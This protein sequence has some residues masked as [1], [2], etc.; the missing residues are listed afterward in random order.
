VQVERAACWRFVGV[1]P[2]GKARVRKA[3]LSGLL[4]STPPGYFLSPL[5]ARTR[6]LK[7][8]RRGYKIYFLYLG[9]SGSLLNTSEHHF[10][11]G[12]VCAHD[13]KIY[14]LRR[15][16]DEL[17]QEILPESPDTLQISSYH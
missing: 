3:A 13:S 14:Y 9:D 8:F 15:Y 7:L 16:L 12:G 10:V 2:H 5:L 17:A 4:E 11:L 1:S 6:G